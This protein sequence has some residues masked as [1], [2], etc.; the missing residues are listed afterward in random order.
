MAM[1]PLKSFKV[2]L[3]SEFLPFVNDITGGKSTDE[4]VRLSL[5]V[6]LFA[7]KK[8]TLARAAQLAGLSL[9]DFIDTLRSYDIPWIEYSKEH[10]QEDEH[11]IEELLNQKE[12]KN[13]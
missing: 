1:E 6:G 9:G 5:A 4:K 10:L 11:A 8:V 2:S 12:E 7:G 3:P 13:E